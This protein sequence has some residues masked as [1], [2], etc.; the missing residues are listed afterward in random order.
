MTKPERKRKSKRNRKTSI[1]AAAFRTPE[2][3]Q[4]ALEQ[5]RAIHPAREKKRAERAMR[6]LKLEE[7]RAKSAQEREE[8]Y[9]RRKAAHHFDPEAP[10]E[11]YTAKQMHTYLKHMG[12]DP[13]HDLIDY[14]PPDFLAS[15][16]FDAETISTQVPQSMFGDRRSGG[17]DYFR[18]YAAA[19]K[20]AFDSGMYTITL[21]L[22]LHEYQP[23]PMHICREVIESS[24]DYDAL[25]LAGGATIN[26]QVTREAVVRAD[27][28]TLDILYYL[29]DHHW[30]IVQQHAYT[31]TISQATLRLRSIPKP[32]QHGG[33]LWHIYTHTD[34]P[35]GILPEDM[36]ELEEL[37][38]KL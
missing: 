10:L 20:I 30:R 26:I 8:N 19:G 25:A 1:P 28:D 24:P 3:N 4:L 9:A 31:Y 35:I 5:D 27:Q 23:M 34:R 21:P 18:P 36:P 32:F 7:E 14:L 6:A 12:P 37:A 17:E 11:I 15:I 38:A 29:R 16:P 13:L 2:E 33:F 22:P